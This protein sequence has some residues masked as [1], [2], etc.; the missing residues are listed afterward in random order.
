MGVKIMGQS[1][2][3]RALA[4]FSGSQG[5]CRSVGDTKGPITEICPDF[6]GPGLHAPPRTKTGRGCCGDSCGEHRDS[7]RI[8]N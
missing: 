6:S 2:A 7:L 8:T 1:Q 4:F 3:G 5:L